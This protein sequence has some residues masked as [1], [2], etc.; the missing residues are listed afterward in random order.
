MSTEDEIWRAIVEANRTWKGGNPQGVGQLFHEDAVQAFANS[1][2]RA[3]GREAIVRD[4]VELCQRLEII[5]FRE[6]QH[7]VDVVGE[8][9][10]A[11]YRFRLTYE[12]N[13]VPHEETGREVL[14]FRRGASGQW[15]A[16]WRAR[17]PESEPTF[18]GAEN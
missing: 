7:S 14:V 12:A 2:R 15:L 1:H 13:G 5:E 10:V 11:N 4:Y 17:F 18:E 16:V 9:A 8:T 6:L 3:V